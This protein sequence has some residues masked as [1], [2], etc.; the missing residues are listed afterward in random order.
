[1]LFARQNIG[2]TTI[3]NR[4]NRAVEELT[5]C[6]SKFGVIS[7]VVVHR[8]LSEHGKVF[9]LRL[10]KRRAVRCDEAHLCLAS[11]KAL[12]ARLVTEDGLSRLHDELEPRVHRLN[13]LLL[14]G[15]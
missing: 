13:I 6:S 14:L 5:A 15:V 11:A 10:T 2:V 9:H 7:T 4:N 8:N 3:N 1:L 12:Q